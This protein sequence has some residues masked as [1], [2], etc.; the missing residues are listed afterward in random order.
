MIN[1]IHGA[2]FQRRPAP[3]L[4]WRTFLLAALVLFGVLAPGSRM[5]A[6]G[7]RPTDNVLYPQPDP[8]PF[9]I[10]PEIGYGWWDNKGGFTVTDG[11]M[12]CTAFNNGKGKGMTFG[13][14][15]FIYLNS[16]FFIS[17][18]IRYEARS[19]SFM[20]N[21]PGE[22]VRD[23]S[24]SVVTLSEEGIVDA[25]FAAATL[26][27]TIGV[28]FF[29]TGIYI[30]GGGSASFLLD[31]FY[32]YS[33]RVTGP[34]A[35]TYSDTRSDR[36]KLV[37]GRSFAGYEKTAFDLRGG[38]G[39]IFRIDRLAINPEVF[40]SSPLTSALSPPDELKQTGIVATLGIMYNIGK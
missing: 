15:A 21:L 13:A 24:D 23:A 38:L 9:L 34:S 5:L 17:P 11:N 40:Y 3:R 28:E 16:W 31:G 33:T 19:G 8:I 20:T 25:T 32:D 37:S 39:Y 6:Q 22:P 30:F 35:F 29:Q 14:K 4:R 36:H 2:R 26:D 1:D 18:R 10:G 27:G 7:G 12:A